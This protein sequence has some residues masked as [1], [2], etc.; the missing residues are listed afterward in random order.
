MSDNS[1]PATIIIKYK[2]DR[3]GFNL[4][5][6]QIQPYANIGRAFN[7]H[8]SHDHVQLSRLDGCTQENWRELKR[9][10]DRECELEEDKVHEQ[11]WVFI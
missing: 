3:F 2:G 9:F 5:A 4:R 8:Q 6:A 7:F 11:R 10:L 1:V